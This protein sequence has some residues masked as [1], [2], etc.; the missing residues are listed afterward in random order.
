VKI[1]LKKI[2]KKKKKSSLV[3]HGQAFALVLFS[4]LGKDFRVRPVYGTHPVDLWS[5]QEKD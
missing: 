4:K 5:K 2:E 1:K 3:F